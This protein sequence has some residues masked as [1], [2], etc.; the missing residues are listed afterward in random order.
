MAPMD[1]THRFSVPAGVHEAWNAFNNVEQLASCFP[2]ATITEV[3]GDEFSGKLKIKLGPSTLVYNGSGRYLERNESERRVVIEAQGEER[4][5]NGDANVTVSASF[6]ES[7]GQTDVDLRTGLV[8]NGKPAHLGEEVIADVSERLL[9]QF[10]TCLSEQFAGGLGPVQEDFLSGGVAAEAADE[11]DETD[12]ERTIELEPVPA[13]P[14]V[15][16]VAAV[17]A[18]A[19]ATP[20]A[21][22]SPSASQSGPAAA[23]RVA[24]FTPPTSEPPRYTTPRD[25]TEQGALNAI[26]TVV[27]VLLKRFG[28]GL[29]ILGLLL[30][31]VIK[32]IRR[33]T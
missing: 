3:R 24:D 16:A 11:F 19:A 8:I 26:G 17:A 12:N 32:I 1:L 9:E 2:G 20:A 6:T 25:D 33:K 13:V 22:T 14:A 31:V 7:A 4:R 30:F 5:R 28:P 18:E 29:A 23:A 27:P 10:V 21:G 15:A